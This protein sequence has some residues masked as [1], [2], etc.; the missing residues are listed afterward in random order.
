MAEET[1]LH[2]SAP[3]PVGAIKDR[4]PEIPGYDI[5]EK[6]SD[7]EAAVIWKGRQ[8]SLDRIVAVKVLK[9]SH[10]DTPGEVERFMREAR[11]IAQLR[12]G[13]LIHIYDVGRSQQAYYFVM[14]HV[15]G[16]ALAA[17]LARDRNVAQKQALSVALVVADTLDSC[18]QTS[19][20]AH[21]DVQPN[22][23]I[24]AADQTV[25]MANV[26]MSH[27]E[28]GAAPGD[29]SS[30]G[31]AHYM[32]PEQFLP[33][34]TPDFRADMYS[35]G[36]VLYH[37]LT[38]VKPFDGKGRALA[39]VAQQQE[40]IADVRDVNPAVSVGAAQLVARLMMK[41]PEHRYGSWAGAIT[42]IKKVQAGKVLLHKHGKARSTVAAPAGGSG[43]ATV[44]VGG[45]TGMASPT[46][47]PR[48]ASYPVLRLLLRVC[49]VG[50]C[51]WVG[52]ILVGLPPKPVLMRTSGAA[53]SPDQSHPRPMPGPTP[54]PTPTFRPEPPPASLEPPPTDV[55]PVPED[56]VTPPPASPVAV[57]S[58]AVDAVA[59]AV[60]DQFLAEDFRGALVTAERA[61]AG[62]RD[63]SEKAGLQEVRDTVAYVANLGANLGD[64]FR[65]RIGQVSDLNHGGAHARIE[66]AAVDGDKVTADV[67]TAGAARRSTVFRISG[68]EP[69]ER[70]RWL[71]PIQ[72]PAVAAAHYALAMQAGDFVGAKQAA[73]QAGLLA[74]ALVAVAEQRIRLLTQ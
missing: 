31:D 60:V 10:G 24:L 14:E 35:L 48:S 61:L 30:R 19:K 50:W 70:A 17:L 16:E 55:S 74:D 33:D 53:R 67:I 5:L 18:W 49:L 6:L 45:A 1:T 68:L 23:I 46:V 39:V 4:R 69:R 51:L 56:A 40:Q 29:P 38:G 36:A 63:P 43:S 26:G 42:A 37:M 3:T 73:S 41:Q 25:K 7:D 34:V 59:G 47:P 32:A 57:P 20:L 65:A 15:E 2:V 12:G 72:S 64:A 52:Y 54:A 28:H 58:P 27:I 21:L 11:A 22:N 8:Q 44:P 71:G 13:G 9:R 66:I 62:A